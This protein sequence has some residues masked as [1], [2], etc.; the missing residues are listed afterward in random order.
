MHAVPNAN[1]TAYSEVLRVL[2]R[3][4]AT[5]EHVECK[6]TERG[7]PGFDALPTSIGWDKRTK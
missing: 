3:Q 4:T 7:G 1:G 6:L 2:F 5:E